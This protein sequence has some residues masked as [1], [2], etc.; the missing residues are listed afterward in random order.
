MITAT[1]TIKEYKS[2]QLVKVKKDVRY[3]L[4]GLHLNIPEKRIESSN[5]H[6]LLRINNIQVEGEDDSKS[7]IINTD[8]K[9]P[10][11][12][13]LIRFKIDMGEVSID[14][15]NEINQTIMTI[16]PKVEDGNFPNTDRVIPD[17][18]LPVE[19]NHIAFNPMYVADVA[20]IYLPKFP[21]VDMKFYKGSMTVNFSDN[22]LLV[23]MPV[24]TEE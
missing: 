4:N 18:N 20:K 3:Y 11:K 14:F 24:R 8:I 17:T 9:A 15:I 12:T 13:L 21:V 2:L 10:P 5:G 23:V 16:N 19:V 6:R 1:I 7:Y 22:I